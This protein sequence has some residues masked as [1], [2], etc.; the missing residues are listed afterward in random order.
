MDVEGPGN[1][2]DPLSIPCQLLLDLT[3]LEGQSVRCRRRTRPVWYKARGPISQPK[4]GLKNL[5]RE[6]ASS[7]VIILEK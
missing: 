5:D 6:P 2:A 3:A 1:G 7:Y 4:L